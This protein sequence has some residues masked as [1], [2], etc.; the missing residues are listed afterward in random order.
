LIICALLLA[1]G[2]SSRLNN[3]LP[4]QYSK[5]NNKPLIC[6]S[7]DKFLKHPK[8]DNIH[9]IINKNHTKFYNDINKIYLS[10]NIKLPK[11]II[12]GPSRQDSVINGLNFLYK[13]P[14]EPNYVIIH[15]VARPFLYNQIINK[16]ISEV[17][18]NLGVVPFLPINDSLKIFDSDKKKYKYIDRNLLI[19][20]QTPQIFCFKSIYKSHLN[21]ENLKLFYDDSS[22][23]EKN[24]MPI[25]FID[26][27]ENN[28][29]ITTNSDMEKA[30]MLINKNDNNFRVGQGFDVHKFTTG[31]FLKLGGVTIPFTKSL[32][33]N[34]DADVVLHSLTDAL[35]GAVGKGDIG[36][37]FPDN[38][39][40]WKDAD[41]ALFLENTMRILEANNT[42]II[43][44]D[45]TIICEKPKIY[46]YK[47]DIKKQISI[48]TKI[49]ENNINI[50]ATTTEKL[51][52]LGREE[53]IACQTIVLVK[54]INV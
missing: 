50:K 41:S 20:I 27:N 34:S 33:G 44:I 35:L 18:E 39:K 29:K 22:V 4:K 13:K 36:E 49:D 43:N 17:E 53:G 32:L 16:L 3:P 11:P 31:N 12:G 1:G 46:S 6:Y 30:N 47:N 15:D 21:I 28:Y 38:T 37:H 2:V 26:G 52:F 10:K 45:I 24:N 54:N 48:L 19:K 51:G 25:K 40:K 7:I 42:I 14:Y 9:I 8:I 23:A 5:I